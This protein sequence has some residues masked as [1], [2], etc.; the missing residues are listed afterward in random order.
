LSAVVA[1]ERI[2]REELLQR[3]L[4]ETGAF[5]AAIASPTVF[6]VERFYAPERVRAFR[7]LAGARA[8]AEPPAW[9]PCLD[10]VPDFHRIVDEYPGAWVKS[11]MHAHYFHRF[12]GNAELFA[13]LH[14]VFRLKNAL[15]GE[16]EDAFL[17][18][19]PSDGVIA[20]IVSNHYPRGGG[21]QAEHQDPTSRFA[22]IQTI[23]QAS[24][25]GVDFREGGLYVRLE[26]GGEPVL[27]DPHSRMGDLLVLSPDIR[28]GVAPVD[29][30]AELDWD[31][32]DGRWMIMPILIR[33][34][35]DTD[36]ANKPL[37]VA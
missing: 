12:N 25:P 14:D 17:D 27:I 13:E 1:I 7:A 28:H 23:I 4:H 34:D 19:I 20:R 37:Q 3:V 18:A 32:A 21:Y 26:E 24:D 22:R 11:R 8:R 6:V 35:Y 30:G 15:A 31:A 36:R 5:L 9:H 16:P 33:S 29:P 10:G 2:S